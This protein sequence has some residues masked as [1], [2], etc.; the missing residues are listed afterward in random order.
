MERFEAMEKALYES[1]GTPSH[2][3]KDPIERALRWIEEEKERR[4]LALQ[5]LNETKY[6]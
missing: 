1:M 2:E 5:E 4:T 3:I 6:L